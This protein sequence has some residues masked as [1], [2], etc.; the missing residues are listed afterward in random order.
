MSL[1][2]RARL[3]VT[4][5]PCW[6]PIGLEEEQQLIDVRLLSS[7]KSIDVNS[8]HAIASLVPLTIAV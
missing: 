8:N 5:V 6:A 7:G 4:P 2:A 1:Q 3:F